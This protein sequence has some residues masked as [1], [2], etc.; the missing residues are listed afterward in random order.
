MAS[1]SASWSTSPS[2]TS[3]CR[4]RSVGF[5]AGFADQL[6]PALVLAAEQLGELGRRHGLWLDALAKQRLARF[7]VLDRLAHLAREQLER[8][9]RR[10]AGREHAVPGARL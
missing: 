9:R 10:S 3:G 2:S 5:D 6:A 7:R 4:R 1:T 8:R